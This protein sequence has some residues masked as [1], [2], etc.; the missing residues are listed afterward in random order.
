MNN[1]YK[2]N[3]IEKWEIDIQALNEP[4]TEYTNKYDLKEFIY[5]VAHQIS[6]MLERG[7]CYLENQVK[8]EIIKYEEFMDLPQLKKV[9]Y[10]VKYDVFM[11]ILKEYGKSL[12]L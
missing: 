7:V 1:Y 5:M 8:Y 3:F 4:D 12:T 9:R 10:W 2:W 11:I 6:R